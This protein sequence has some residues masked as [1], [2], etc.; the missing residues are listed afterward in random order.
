MAR[1]SKLH[2]S[3]SELLLP[4]LRESPAPM[5]AYALL[6]AVKPAGIKSA[7][8][9]YRALAALEQQGLIHKVHAISAYVACKCTH[10]HTHSLSMLMVCGSC[11]SVSE[12]HDDTL[13]HAFE[14]LMAPVHLRPNAVIELPV[15]CRNCA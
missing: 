13:I 11:K 10:N 8:I 4:I 7:P 3:P 2:A 6:E 5:S 9:I 15:T 14:H 1:P 12:L